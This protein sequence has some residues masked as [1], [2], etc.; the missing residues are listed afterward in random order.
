MNGDPGP[1]RLMMVAPRCVPICFPV[2]KCRNHMRNRRSTES[3]DDA[4]F[5]Q[6][7]FCVDFMKL[8]VGNSIENS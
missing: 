7:F 4:A 5:R 3:P 6:A 8:G 1:L 2:E